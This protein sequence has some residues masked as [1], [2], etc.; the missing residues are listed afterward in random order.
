MVVHRR[1]SPLLLRLATL[2]TIYHSDS[3]AWEPLL[4]L[5]SYKQMRNDVTTY[6]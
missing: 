4:L 2:L 6:L 1:R 5:S 3:G